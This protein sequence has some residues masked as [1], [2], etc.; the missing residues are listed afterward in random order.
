MPNFLPFLWNRPGSGSG[1]T[2]EQAGA[3]VAINELLVAI[4]GHDDAAVLHVL[5]GGW[6]QGEIVSFSTLRVRGGFLVSA[7]A[8][9]G[10]TPELVSLSIESLAGNDIS[11]YWPFS[12]LPPRVLANG[13]NV[14]V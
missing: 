1:C 14:T 6:P 13:R 10:D 5:P 7:D 2:T 8:V 9:G 12:P 4:H 11:L 3:T